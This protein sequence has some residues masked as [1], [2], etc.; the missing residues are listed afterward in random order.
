MGN[1]HSHGGALY[2]GRRV[3]F[4]LGDCEEIAETKLEKGSLSSKP[5]FSVLSVSLWSSSLLPSSHQNHHPLSVELPSTHVG[6]TSSCASCDA[7][8]PGAYPPPVVSGSLRVPRLAWL[9]A[10]SPPHAP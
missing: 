6:T 3:K 9:R 2:H 10:A 5:F 7:V 1:N 4:T 8:V